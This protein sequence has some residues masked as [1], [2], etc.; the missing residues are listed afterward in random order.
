M[1]KVLLTVAL[2]SS[3][4]FANA[5]DMMSKRGTPIL[6][7]AKDWSI[8]FNAMPVLEYFGN[9]ASG[10]VGRN[11]AGIGYQTPWTIVGKMMKDENTAYRVKVRIGF[12]SS[13]NDFFTDDE[14]S[15]TTPKAQVTDTKKSSSM[16]ITLGGGIQKYRG[17]GR[18]KGYYGAEAAIMLGS[19][20]DTYSYGN[21]L[22]S[23]NADASQ[24]SH[25]FGGNI[26]NTD[27]ITEDKSGSTFGFGIRGFIGA[28][29]F[30]A[31]KMSVGAE[32]GWGISL[33]ST[34]EGNTTTESWDATATAVKSTSVK[35]AGSSTFNIDVDN[36]E[37]AL[38]LSL[39]F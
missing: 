8:G 35:S 4:G 33:N 30:F 7:E 14:T 12:G 3:I 34:G 31:P 10:S 27:R 19:S 5:Q 11:T 17:K 26:A 2:L 29:Y 13:S 21:A 25:D 38:V 15:T 20:K 16:N 6:P 1:K 9:V 18:L 22:N 28:E 23:T 36:L 37:G 39:Y 24:N 32:Y